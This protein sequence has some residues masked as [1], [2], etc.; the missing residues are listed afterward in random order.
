MQNIPMC[1]EIIWHIPSY[2]PP[3]RPSEGLQ[4]KIIIFLACTNLP[5]ARSTMYWV[6]LWCYLAAIHRQRINLCK[7]DESW[8]VQ[9]LETHEKPKA[10]LNSTDLLIAII[11]TTW[12]PFCLLLS[13]L[14]CG[15]LVIVHKKFIQV[16]FSNR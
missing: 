5:K 6:W 15:F 14:L 3:V 12:I 11:G 4:L 9:S 1:L 8:V 16:T 13:S 10:F 7:L 2:F